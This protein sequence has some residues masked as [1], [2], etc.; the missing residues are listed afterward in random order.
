[1]GRPPKITAKNPGLAASAGNNFTLNTI[2]EIS[3]F[4]P[5]FTHSQLLGD[6]GKAW[7]LRGRNFDWSIDGPKSGYGTTAVGTTEIEPALLH[8]Q[9][10]FWKVEEHTQLWTAGVVYGCD[11]DCAPLTELYR[12][13]WHHYGT[14]LDHWPWSIAYVGQVYFFSHPCA[15]IIYFDAHKQ[16]WGKHQLDPY[17]WSSPIYG[18]CAARNRLVVLTRDTVAWSAMDDGFQLGCDSFYAGGGLQSLDEIGKGTPYGVYPTRT[19]WTTFTSNGVMSSQELAPTRIKSADLG[20]SNATTGATG[21]YGDPNIGD[22]RFNHDWAVDQIVP[23]N[24]NCIAQLAGFQQLVLT[25]R[26]FQMFDG[27]RALSELND[28][29]DWQTLIGAYL[30]SK[31]IPQRLDLTDPA[32]AKLTYDFQDGRL[33][34]AFRDAKYAP[35]TRALCYQFDYDKWGSFD[36]TFWCI[37]PTHMT[38]KRYEHANALGYVDQWGMICEFAPVTYRSTK[39]TNSAEKGDVGTCDRVAVSLDS[40]IEVGP[41]RRTDFRYADRHTRTGE[42][43]LDMSPVRGSQNDT[44]MHTN[45]LVDQWEETPLFEIPTKCHAFISSSPDAHKVFYDQFEPLVLV[46]ADGRRRHYAS[47]NTGIMHTITLKAN[48]PHDYFHLHTVHVTAHNAG[49]N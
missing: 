29:G 17:C 47:D 16:L 49:R 36:D 33:F 35:F 1:M 38:R 27:G 19:G 2:A 48:M 13:D 18:I 5:Q 45:Q 12:F 6:M 8:Y 9:P 46:A 28:Q 39:R 15:G 25:K 10:Q 22:P 20:G 40:Y 21:L 37:G 4:A 23:I 30:S 41:F 3:G 43:V 34:V 24:P 42:I 32:A 7:V 26:G 11:E 14:E 44:H 31:E